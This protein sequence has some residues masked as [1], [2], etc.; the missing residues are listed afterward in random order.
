MGSAV[1][2]NIYNAVVSVVHQ[3]RG[4][5]CATA[6]RLDQRWAEMAGYLCTRC[7]AT[8]PQHSRGE[9]CVRGHQLC[10]GSSFGAGAAGGAVAHRKPHGIV[11]QQVGNIWFAS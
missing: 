4:Q 3:Q 1:V 9:A 6:D 7:P 10:D 11:A 5:E 8:L 2:H